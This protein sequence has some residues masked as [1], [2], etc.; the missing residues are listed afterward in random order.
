[1]LGLRSLSLPVRK[2]RH[3]IKKG[4]RGINKSRGLDQGTLIK[5]L[6]PI[7]RGWLLLN[8]R[9]P[10]VF[11]RLWHLVVW[12]LLKW[13]RHRHRNKGR[14]WIRLKYFKS[15]GGDN[16]FFNQRGTIRADTT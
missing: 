15:I 2:V 5:K 16:W 6:N 3:A 12:K 9:Q 11:E 4:S 13:G 1:L 7:I 10:K 8:R 14:G